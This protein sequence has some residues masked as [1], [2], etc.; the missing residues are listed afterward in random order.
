MRPFPFLFATLGSVFLQLLNAQNGI[1]EFS[2]SLNEYGCDHSR[3]GRIV[4]NDVE[5]AKDFVTR[6]VTPGGFTPLMERILSIR[7]YLAKGLRSTS[8]ETDGITIV[9]ATDGLPT[10]DEGHRGHLV[11]D[12]FISALR[13]LQRLSP[14][15]WIVIRLCT[16]DSNVVS[17]YNS[18]DSQLELPLEVLDDF[19]DEAEEVHSHNPWLN[20]ALPLHR[21]R[22][23]GLQNRVLD[24][25]DERALTKGELHDFCTFLFGD[26]I[27]VNGETLPDPDID[28]DGF[29]ARL[30][31][32]LKGEE[33]EWNPT[34]RKR[35]PW[36]DMRELNRTYREGFL[37]WPKNNQRA[38]VVFL[39]GLFSALVFRLFLAAISSDE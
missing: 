38:F 21:C 24:L 12:R 31:E 33:K 18:L 36:I 20:Y 29:T 2:V 15:V 1:S 9:I 11:T 37:F 6:R 5:R 17:F 34:R 16:N 22:E 39:V 3:R 32:V 23:F 8:V 7:E 13:D 4:E 26:R 10:D 14:S 30:N 25:L 35:A 19:M 28:W 27:W